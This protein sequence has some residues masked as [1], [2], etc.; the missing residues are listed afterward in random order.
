MNKG[1]VNRRRLNQLTTIGIS[2]PFGEVIQTFDATRP[3]LVVARRARR[4]RAMNN[5][6]GR[7]SEHE[8]RLS[9]P[10]FGVRNPGRTGGLV[11][12]IL[13]SILEGAPSFFWEWCLGKRLDGCERAGRHRDSGGF[14]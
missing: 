6:T 1:S 4:A 11:P 13:R 5:T 3:P 7:T 14:L 9:T 2:R 12:L 10:Q 8:P